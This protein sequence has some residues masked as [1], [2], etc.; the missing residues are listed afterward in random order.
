MAT[1]YSAV[2]AARQLVIEQ[3]KKPMDWEEILREM[4]ARRGK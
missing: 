2:Q 1:R 3:E 4:T